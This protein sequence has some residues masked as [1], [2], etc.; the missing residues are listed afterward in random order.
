MKT[1]ST[2]NDALEDFRSADGAM[3]YDQ[4]DKRWGA[5][6]TEEIAG[7]SDETPKTQTEYALTMGGMTET[8]I[9]NELSDWQE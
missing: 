8:E 2:F 1:Y 9:A 5:G 4:I 7:L 6:E 3:N